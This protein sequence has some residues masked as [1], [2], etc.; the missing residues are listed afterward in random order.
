MDVIDIGIGC[1]LIGFGLILAGIGIAIA[2]E[3]YKEY[4][5]ERSVDG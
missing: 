5:K 1:V 2:L 4:K 3:V